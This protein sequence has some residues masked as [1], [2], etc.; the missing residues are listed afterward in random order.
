[1]PWFTKKRKKKESF[2]FS[3][4]IQ[5]RFRPFPA[6]FGRF[7]LVSADTTWNGQYGP[8]L[9]ESAR[10]G[11]NRSRFGTNRVALARIEPSWRES[12]KKKK[13]A[14]ADRRVGNRVGRRVPCRVASDA[15]AAPLVPYLCFLA[16][17]SPSS[18]LIYKGNFDAAFFDALG[19]AGI[20]MVF[21]D[22]MG[23]IIVALSQKIPLI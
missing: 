3:S 8:I 2:G 15:G 10:F 19:Y 11:A 17:W 12:E 13:N 5:G 6:C 1:M 4:H 23:Q 18:E 22:H 7:Q 9:A 16:H 21:H 20:G 14:D